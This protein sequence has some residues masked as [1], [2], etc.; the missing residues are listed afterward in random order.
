M[1]NPP[2]ITVLR[3]SLNSFKNT[4]KELIVSTLKKVDWGNRYS[5]PIGVKI[6]LTRVEKQ[7]SFIF[8]KSETEK[9]FSDATQN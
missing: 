3:G 2:G 1:T 8:I 5:C 7:T 9:E 4:F 6:H